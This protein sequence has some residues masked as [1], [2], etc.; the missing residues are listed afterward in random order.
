[1]AVQQWPLSCDRYNALQIR[2]KTKIAAP[3]LDF[4]IG[5]RIADVKVLKVALII[6]LRGE[7]SYMS[8]DVNRSSQ[9]LIISIP[10]KVYFP[11]YAINSCVSRTH[12]QVVIKLYLLPYNANVLIIANRLLSAWFYRGHSPNLDFFQVRP[13]FKEISEGK[14]PRVKF[15]EYIEMNEYQ[16]IQTRMLGADSF[17][18]RNIT[19]TSDV[20]D[21]AIDALNHFYFVGLQEEFEISAK[22]LI[23][24]MQIPNDKAQSI[25]L[26]N[27]R[28]QGSNKNI[29]KQKEEILNNDELMNRVREVNSY[30]IQLYQAGKWYD[31]TFDV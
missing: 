17:P 5:M 4:V 9:F 2:S 20:Y 23:R 19:I 31:Y 25:T 3:I 30:D 16:N 28:E 8:L 12:R 24:E 15:P 11:K 21:K 1:M 27:E 13:E 29:K 14:R 6:F 26:V 18:Y 22:L 7:N 10:Q